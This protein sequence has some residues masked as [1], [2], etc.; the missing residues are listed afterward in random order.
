LAAPLGS[1]LNPDELRHRDRANRLKFREARRAKVKQIRERWGTDIVKA[2]GVKEELSHHFWRL[3][4]L[5]RM[6]ALATEKKNEKLISRIDKLEQKEIERHEKAMSQLKAQA[7]NVNPESSAAPA[8]SVV[9]NEMPHHVHDGA[10]KARE[11]AHEGGQ[12]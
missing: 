2:P 5:K 6:R 1:V 9:P 11:K 8:S 4:R 7:S 3:A 12:P 10:K